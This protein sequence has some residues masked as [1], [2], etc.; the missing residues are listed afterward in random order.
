ML[1]PFKHLTSTKQLSRA[2]TD[3]ILKVAE[4]MEKVL[5][6]GGN[7][8]LRHK[9]LATLFYEPSTR[10]RLSFESAMLR[11]GGQVVSAVGTQFSSMYKGETVEDTIMMAGQYAD[12]I[13]M[14][15]PEA[16]SA[17]QAAAV[18]PIPFIN[19]G[20][21][22]AQHPTQGLLDL[23]TVKKERGKLEGIHVAMVGDLKYGRTVHS[24]SF[25]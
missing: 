18:S 21:G 23:Y 10:T 11:L 7:D 5:R 2:D 24:L 14:R 22:P 9:V 12:I 3:A 13:A 17:D 1:L 16:G 15:H 6:G 4:Q 20:D 19:A 25:L 8:L